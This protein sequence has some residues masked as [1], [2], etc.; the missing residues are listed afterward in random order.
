VPVWAGRS[1]RTHPCSRHAAGGDGKERVIWQPASYRGICAPVS[2]RAPGHCW[3]RG[4][5]KARRAPAPHIAIHSGVCWA[6]AMQQDDRLLL[7]VPAPMTMV[8]AASA[9]MSTALVGRVRRAKSGLAVRWL[10]PPEA[11][12][13]RLSMRPSRDGPDGHPCPFPDVC[14]RLAD[15]LAAMKIVPGPKGSRAACRSA[16][17]SAV[18]VL[19]QQ[20][21]SARGSAS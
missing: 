11:R 20:R 17:G 13:R 1:C 16:G 2:G 7:R 8:I 14:E 12:E 9:G 4:P 19:P 6:P 21:Q 10:R 3:K 15:H 5:P 18:M